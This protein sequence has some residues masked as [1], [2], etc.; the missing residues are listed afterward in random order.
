MN[1][2]IARPLKSLL[3]VVLHAVGMLVPGT[4]P[5]VLMYHSI[6][7]FK[8]P[9][10]VSPAQFAE[11]MDYL[12]AKGY[13]TWTASRFVDAVRDR[14]PFPKKLAVLTFDD[15]Y[16]NNVTHALPI[17]EQRGLCA[18]VFMVT[19]NDGEPPKWGERDLERIRTQIDEDF[20]GSAED[21]KK[22]EA[23][24]MA[25]L[26]E[27]IATWDELAPAPARGLEVLSH[28]RTHHFMDSVGDEQLTDE[29]VGSRDDL[30]RRG[31]G[32]S[33]SLAWPY[34]KYDSDAMEA[35]RAAGYRG[36]FLA[37]Y[38]RELRDFSDPWRIHR[39]GVD[40]SRGM[41]GFAFAL[42]RGYDLMAWLKELRG[43]RKPA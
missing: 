9:I 16:L 25:T 29:L 43:K 23:Q 31:F 41:F 40:G 2:K 10:S 8:S 30:E 22:I 6:D 1:Q 18:T 39:V 27:K 35:A 11:Q 37:G 17:L 24:V 32:T 3:R 13:T 7:D 15:G 38:H 20:P 19:N 42:G 14:Q 4:P 36:A 33:N 12:V 21:K 28:T 5:R 34:G 26:T